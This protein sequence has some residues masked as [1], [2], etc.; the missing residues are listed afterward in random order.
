M[1]E[2][3]L[4]Y[5]DTHCH[6]DE[7]EDPE[8][9]WRQAQDAGVS[10]LIIPGLSPMQWPKIKQLSAQCPNIYYSVGIHPFSIGA[11]EAGCR[12]NRDINCNSFLDRLYS[13][14]Q[15][16]NCIAIGEC[17]LDGSRATPIDD[18]L[19]IFNQ[20][21]TLACELAKPLI[22][23]AHKAHHHILARLAYYKPTAGGVIHGFSGSLALAQDYW[24]KG[25]YIGLGGSITYSRASKTQHMATQMPL[26]ALV[27]ETDAP[28]MPLSGEQ[29]Q[30]NHP[31]KV[32][33]VAKTL[34]ALRKQ[35]VKSIAEHT[36]KNACTLFGLSAF[37]VT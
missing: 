30:A 18:Q 36:T 5:I 23:H 10:S 31:A 27:L 35:S 17:G 24:R 6:L 20:Q 32:V 11:S 37:N 25:F 26:E 7:T 21:V 8:L 12:D 3:P 29:G 16:S 1:S 4:S 9:V 34:A 14:V 22:I 15:D 13:Y 28:Y 2:K 19:Q 33:R